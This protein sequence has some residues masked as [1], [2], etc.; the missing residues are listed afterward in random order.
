MHFRAAVSAAAA[1][2]ATSRGHRRRRLLVAP[3]ADLRRLLAASRQLLP[4]THSPLHPLGPHPLLRAP[5]SPR[6][7]RP[8]LP[9]AAAAPPGPCTCLALPCAAGLPGSLTLGAGKRAEPRGQTRLG[10][11]SRARARAPAHTRTGTRAHRGRGGQP[12]PRSRSRPARVEA[13]PRTPPSL[14]TQTLVHPTP[15]H[16]PPPTGV[17]PPTESSAWAPLHSRENSA[18]SAHPPPTP[19]AICPAPL[20][21]PTNDLF[22]PPQPPQPLQHPSFPTAQSTAASLLP[23]L[24]QRPLPSHARPQIQTHF[25][26]SDLMAAHKQ[27]CPP[28]RS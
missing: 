10:A 13:P 8:P 7:R 16:T 21:S 19:T 25:Q 4:D 12:R 18:A 1:R 20:R 14:A 5:C 2:P 22:P 3:L 28:S 15:T 24:L 27:Y 26:L 6:R 17:P 11:Y 9:R 23:K